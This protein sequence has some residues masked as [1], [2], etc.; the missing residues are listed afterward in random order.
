QTTERLTVAEWWKRRS[1]ILDLEPLRV[2]TPAGRPD[3]Q[4]KPERVHA[5]PGPHDLAPVEPV[6][7]DARD[8]HPLACPGHG[9]EHSEMRPL[10]G[11][12]RHDFVAFRD[13]VVDGELQVRERFPIH[14][15]RPL[16]SSEAL[17]CIR[18]VRVVVN[19]VGRDE[20]VEPFKVAAAPDLEDDPRGCLVLL[21]HP[22]LLTVWSTC[23]A[24]GAPAEFAVEGLLRLAR[25]NTSEAPQ[26]E[27]AAPKA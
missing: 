1:P 3:R 5:P 24:V 21:R 16:H 20:L 4:P 26:P 13:L 25:H 18:V 10:P 6:D 14:L 2:T 19:D 11:P 12:A 27:Q 23:G 9:A 22:S 15:D 8:R 17:G 7:G